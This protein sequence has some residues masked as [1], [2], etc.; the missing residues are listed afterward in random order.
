[1]TID[2][3]TETFNIFHI[4]ALDA[5]SILSSLY[6]RLGFSTHISTTILLLLS[7]RFHRFEKIRAPKSETTATV[8]K[9]SAKGFLFQKSIPRQTHLSVHKAVQV[10]GVCLSTEAIDPFASVQAL[11]NLGPQ[12]RSEAI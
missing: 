8:T 9:S 12:T 1:M 6:E 10:I 11:V 3:F 4:Y 2:I 5:S 7:L